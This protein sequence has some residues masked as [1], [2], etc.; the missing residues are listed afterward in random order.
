M[1]YQ[2]KYL[3]Y[4]AKYEIL[5]SKKSN[6]QI[7]GVDKSITINCKQAEVLSE[8]M[9]LDAR[10]GKDWNELHLKLIGWRCDAATD[11]ILVP[12]AKTYN[13][14]SENMAWIDT[15]ISSR[16]QDTPGEKVYTLIAKDYIW[17]RP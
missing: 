6:F 14:S 8:Y 3:K 12:N 4:K 16:L 2:K 1:D 5:L 9:A 17:P 15:E 11:H 13:I 10:P 7:G